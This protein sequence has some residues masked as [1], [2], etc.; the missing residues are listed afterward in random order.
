[1]DAIN[2]DAYEEDMLSAD[3]FDDAVIGVAF[4][5]ASQPILA[6]DF[7]KC[8]EI[9]MERDGMDR[10]GAI[11]HMEFNVVGSYVGDGTPCFIHPGSM[12]GD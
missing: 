3:G 11:E 10:D 8:V 6:Y 9:L 1:M 2:F 4:R 5:C 7:D 12:W